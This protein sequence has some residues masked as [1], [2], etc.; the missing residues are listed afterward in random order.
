MEF[1]RSGCKILRKGGLYQESVLLLVVLHLRKYVEFSFCLV[2]FLFE[3]CFSCLLPDLKVL[4]K[5]S[6]ITFAD[7]IRYYFIMFQISWMLQGE[8]K[9][10]LRSQVCMY[11]S[12]KWVWPVSDLPSQL[13]LLCPYGESSTTTKPVPIYLPISITLSLTEILSIH[14]ALALLP[15]RIMLFLLNV[16]LLDTQTDAVI[17]PKPHEKGNFNLKQT[18][19]FTSLL[20][21]QD[22]RPVELKPHLEPHCAKK[23]RHTELQKNG[24]KKWGF[25]LL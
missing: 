15:H 7:Q 5:Y 8:Y 16:D 25:Y 9:K 1:K 17:W 24:N 11:I 10:H 12:V 3:N 13:D 2:S 19:I 18:F 6:S 14:S 20:W 4:Y 21:L 22:A 23:Q